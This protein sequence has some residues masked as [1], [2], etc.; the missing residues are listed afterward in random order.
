MNYLTVPGPNISTVNH[1][2]KDFYTGI[3]SGSHFAAEV[4]FIGYGIAL[5]L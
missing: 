1:D 5:Q 3:V 2:G 4:E